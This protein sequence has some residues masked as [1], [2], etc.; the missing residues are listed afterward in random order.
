[1]ATGTEEPASYLPGSTSTYQP[2]NSSAAPSSDSSSA[3]PRAGTGVTPANYASPAPSTTPAS[4][5]L[6]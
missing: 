1:M 2:Q 4:G 3:Y 6:Y 5:R